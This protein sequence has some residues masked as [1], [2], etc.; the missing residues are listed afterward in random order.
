M[1]RVYIFSAPSLFSYAFQVK[2]KLSFVIISDFSGL[3]PKFEWKSLF[4]EVMVTPRLNGEE[5][6]TKD[7]TNSGL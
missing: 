1:L 5:E 2:G 4:L 3:P 7:N 6:G